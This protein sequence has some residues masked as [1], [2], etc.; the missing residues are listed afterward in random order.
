MQELSGIRPAGIDLSVLAT[1]TFPSTKQT[2]PQFAATV[3]AQP[4]L[5]HPSL[6]QKKIQPQTEQKYFFSRNALIPQPTQ[7]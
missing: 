4:K 7:T 5:N 2:S 3:L 1:V 6:H